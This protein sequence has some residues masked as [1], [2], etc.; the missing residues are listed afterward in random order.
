MVRAL[1]VVLP[2]VLLV[3]CRGNADDDAGVTT[4]T[5]FEECNHGPR[6]HADDLYISLALH[7]N[8]VEHAYDEGAPVFVCVNAHM[9]G[10]AS[11]IVPEGVTVTPERRRVDPTGNGV[12]RFTVR[13]NPGASGQVY[14]RW[15]SEAGG[16]SQEGPEVVTDDDHWSFEGP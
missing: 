9:G 6:P 8:D 16:G 15:S 4:P 2:A 3:G 13:V 14:G 7:W 5:R 12:L 10:E 1:P 11:L